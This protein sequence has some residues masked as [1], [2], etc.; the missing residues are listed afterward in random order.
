MD[1]ENLIKEVLESNKEGLKDAVR[2]QIEGKILDQLSYSLNHKVSEV[3]GEFVRDEVADEIKAML[4]K[5]KPKMLKEMESGI[6][7]I[8]AALSECL[9]A[10]ALKNLEV[11]SYKSREIL[12]KVFD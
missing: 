5:A 11:G 2:K 3:V 1:T 9:Y 8:G 12:K 7:K 4:T 6:V 10:K